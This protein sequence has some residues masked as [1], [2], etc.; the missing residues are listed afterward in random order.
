M[1]RSQILRRRKKDEEM[2][3]KGK[4]TNLEEVLGQLRTSFDF[5]I[6]NEIP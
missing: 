3:R 6:D 1:E 2:E 5:E 4:L